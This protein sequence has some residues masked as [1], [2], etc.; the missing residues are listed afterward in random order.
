MEQ[1]TFAEFVAALW[2]KQGWQT[3]VTT[4]SGKSFVTL[5]REGA[6]GLIWAR[7]ATG[8][9]VSGQELQQFVKLCKQYD[10]GEGAVVTS[11]TFGEDAQK[12]GKQTGVQ[13]VDSEKLRTII[14]ARELHDLVREYADID[15][16]GERSDGG[17]ESG[18]DGR[19]LPF[20]LPE[21]SPISPKVGVGIVVA[22]LA[23]LGATV[24]APTILGT[25]GDVEAKWNVTANSTTPTNT[26]KSL[27]VQWN[28]ERVSKLSPEGGDGV[29]RP[30]ENEQFLIVSMNVTNK[31]DDSVG[32]RPRDFGVRSNGTL[33]GYHPLKNAS[34][35]DP[36]VLEDGETATVW[37]VFSIDA[38]AT[39]ATIVV[40]ERARH[41][42]ARF[43]FVRDP[44]LSPDV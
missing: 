25:G 10:V 42:G 19:S 23:I 21:S 44:N 9:G 7:P 16:D 35:F 36:M 34:G 17:D 2:K 13:L 4:K 5:Q 14:E 41:G 22:I 37:L 29:Y 40:S 1:S 15:A 3:Q 31:G 26:T 43:R 18:D 27:A 24:V 20:S 33:R 12:I 6:E 28:A 38:D 8:E 11:G 32:L 39:N 30:D